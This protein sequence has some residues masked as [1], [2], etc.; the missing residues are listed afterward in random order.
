M[1]DNY[2]AEE[3]RNLNLTEECI[4][5]SFDPKRATALFKAGDSK[6]TDSSRTGSSRCG[7]SWAGLWK[8]LSRKRNNSLQTDS[9]V[10]IGRI[11]PPVAGRMENRGLGRSVGFPL[12][13][14]RHVPCNTSYF[15]H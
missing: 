8:S 6:L 4:S 11:R 10:W 15:L 2:T 5:I 7:N 9:S 1:P 3:Q 13:T 14:R 12:Q